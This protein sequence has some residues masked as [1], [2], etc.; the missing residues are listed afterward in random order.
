MNAATPSSSCQ[1][2]QAFFRCPVPQ[3]D[4]AATIRIGAKRMRAS[5]AE[6]SIDGFT[7]MITPKYAK[8]IQMGGTWVLDFQETR[9]EVHPQWFFQSPE[10]HVQLGLRRLRDLTKTKPIRNSWRPWPS[11]GRSDH[12]NNSTI[13]FG[14]FVL[15]LIA[16]LSTTRLG[17]QLGTADKIESAFKWVVGELDSQFG[18]WL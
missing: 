6:T 7:V 9:T 1:T 12:S 14:G 4:G 18:R 13:M 8:R 16:V 2:Q 15:A 17:E 5:V 3:S 10:G 11:A